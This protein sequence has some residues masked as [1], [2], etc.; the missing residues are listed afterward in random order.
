MN[1]VLFQAITLPM[2]LQMQCPK[3]KKILTQGPVIVIAGEAGKV[4]G[5]VPDTVSCCGK[6]AL[7]A[8]TFSQLAD[9]TAFIK[10]IQSDHEGE[11]FTL[12]PAKDLEHILALVGTTITE[13]QV[14]FSHALLM[15]G[16]QNT[17]NN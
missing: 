7:N 9:A 15:R 3:C 8:K 6:N 1:L 12:S 5:Y 13:V 11:N 10:S 14:L 4:I 16:D 2:T 17:P